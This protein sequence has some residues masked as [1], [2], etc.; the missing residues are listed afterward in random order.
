MLRLP[1]RLW[2]WCLPL[3]GL[4][5]LAALLLRQPGVSP[6]RAP[7]YLE[8]RQ[9]P[10]Q[11]EAVSRYEHYLRQQGVV[12]VL[13]MP[14][15]LSARR[16]WR[17]CGTAPWVLPPEALWPNMVPT[18]RLLRALQQQGLPGEVEVT[19][20]FRDQALNRC[21]RGAPQSRHRDNTALD[22]RLLGADTTTRLTA[23]CRFWRRQGAALHM[24]LGFYEGGQIHIDS[25]GYRT[26]GQ[27]FTRASSPC[28]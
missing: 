28:R 15:L 18:L 3:L 22:L 20:S 1:R 21:A 26:W 24:G 9:A 17:Q 27:D 8:W 10:A 13:P 19:S 14:A 5:G 4:I 16:D 7:Q 6:P 23:L 2:L 25:A 11:R 12:D